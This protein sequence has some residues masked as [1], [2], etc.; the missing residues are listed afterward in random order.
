[1]N[2][3]WSNKSDAV[4]PAITPRFQIG[5]QWRGVTGPERPTRSLTHW[6]LGIGMLLIVAC[7][8]AHSP[9]TSGI[10]P[11]PPPIQ[12]EE[13]RT[14]GEIDRKL[15]AAKTQIELGRFDSGERILQNILDLDPGNQRAFYY[16]GL[17]ARRTWVDAQRGQWTGQW[18]VPPHTN[19]LPV[20]S[21]Y[22]RGL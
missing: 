13:S 21:P 16:L 18:E 20:P 8:C 14:D 17:I 10:H 22:P 4:S 7:G 6:H 9:M 1:M 15:S 19:A 12:A 11:Q 3:T 5:H 2:A